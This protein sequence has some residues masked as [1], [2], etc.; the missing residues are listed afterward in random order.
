MASQRT[1]K[2]SVLKHVLSEMNSVS[3]LLSLPSVPCPGASVSPLVRAGDAFEHGSER[4]EGK[5]CSER[6]TRSML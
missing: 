1:M 3:S 4:E 6:S 5:E 2:K